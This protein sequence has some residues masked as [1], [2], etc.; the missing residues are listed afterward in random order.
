MD[1]EG[2]NLSLNTRSP[3]VDLLLQELRALH[4]DIAGDETGFGQ[5]TAGVVNRRFHEFGDS[6]V[7]TGVVA[8]ES[9][10]P[11]AGARVEAPGL[12]LSAP[13]DEAGRYE[14]GSLA[15]GPVR[16]RASAAEHVPQ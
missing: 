1:L 8:S 9:G 7:V 5:A 2:R 14:I 15:P 13:A 12:G 10:E 11:T 16:L 3:D 4:F 6:G